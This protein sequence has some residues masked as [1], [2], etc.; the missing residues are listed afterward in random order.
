MAGNPVGAEEEEAAGK[1]STW[2]RR[3]GDREREDGR[4]Q[5]HLPRKS[6]QNKTANCCFVVD[7]GFPSILRVEE[8]ATNR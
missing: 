7:L 8:T 1:V 3:R 6:D 2:G 5:P 4:V